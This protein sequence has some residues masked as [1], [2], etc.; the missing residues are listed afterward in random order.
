MC[1]ERG[2]GLTSPPWLGSFEEQAWLNERLRRYKGCGPRGIRTVSITR[3]ERFALN[4]VEPQ[5]PGPLGTVMC[6]IPQQRDPRGL[7]FSS[8][9]RI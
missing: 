1:G 4:Y 9:Q 6:L 2:G 3:A 8:F 7:A 5:R